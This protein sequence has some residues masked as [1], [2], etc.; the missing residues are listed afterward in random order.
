MNPSPDPRPSLSIRRII[1]LV[2]AV[3]WTVA[4]LVPVPIHPPPESGLQL[5]LWASSK[6]LHVAAYA[7]F[8]GLAAW[9]RLPRRQRIPLLLLLVGHTMLTEYLQWVLR[10]ITHRTGQWSDVGLDCIG[11]AVGVV[12]TWKRWRA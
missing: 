12:L 3:A 8:T 6:S 1:W 7:L 5:P 2:Y 11:I 9:M 4:L 10:D